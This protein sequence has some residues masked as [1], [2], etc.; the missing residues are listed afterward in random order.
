MALA[1]FVFAYGNICSAVW[2]QAYQFSC[3]YSKLAMKSVGQNEEKHEKKD[4][5]ET[6]SLSQQALGLSF[7]LSN[8]YSEFGLTDRLCVFG[9]IRCLL[10]DLPD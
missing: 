10:S 3:R 9:V 2:E 4:D 1:Q 7:K 8:H 5:R 6:S